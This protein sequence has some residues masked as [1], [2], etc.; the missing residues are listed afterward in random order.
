MCESL[1]WCRFFFQDQIW[2]ALQFIV[3]LVSIVFVI[4]QLSLQ[5]RSHIVTTVHILDEVWK[6]NPMLRTRYEVCKKWLNTPAGRPGV[7]AAVEYLFEYFEQI[8]IYYRVRALSKV[9]IWELYSW[10]MERYYEMYGEDIRALRVQRNDPTLYSGIESLVQI[11]V[12]ISRKRGAPT[13]FDRAALEDFVHYEMEIAVTL[14]AMRSNQIATSA[15]IVSINRA[16]VEPSVQTNTDKLES[17]SKQA[18]NLAN[19]PKP[20]AAQT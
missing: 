1:S 8:A 6:S 3:V 9:V 18:D 4:R 16:S 15:P 13:R 7:D 17:P 2:E 12:A 14:E 5:S 10:H 11:I 19:L 20:P